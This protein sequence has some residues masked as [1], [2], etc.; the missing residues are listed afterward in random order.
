MGPNRKLPNTITVS[1]LFPVHKP[2]GSAPVSLLELR[3]RNFN[4]PF[5][6]R[7]GGMLPVKLFSHSCNTSSFGSSPMNSGIE[8]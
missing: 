1:R 4:L 6:P 2:A 8:P 7:P 5:N 3:S